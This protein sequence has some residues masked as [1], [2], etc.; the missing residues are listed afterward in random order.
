M[1]WYAH[2]FILGEFIVEKIGKM[3]Y[4]NVIKRIAG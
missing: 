3:D 1:F 2:S 4:D